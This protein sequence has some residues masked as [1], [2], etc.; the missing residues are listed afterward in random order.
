M[1]TWAALSRG[2]RVVVKLRLPGVKREVS[3]RAVVKWGKPAQV[4]GKDAFEIGA[5]FVDLDSEDRL[6]LMELGRGGKPV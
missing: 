5:E 2:D 1:R 4:D 3:A 6:R